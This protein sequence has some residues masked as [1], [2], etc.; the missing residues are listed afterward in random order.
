MFIKCY[1]VLFTRVRDF[2]SDI[3]AHANA[4]KQEPECPV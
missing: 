2:H 3:K 1:Y 4:L